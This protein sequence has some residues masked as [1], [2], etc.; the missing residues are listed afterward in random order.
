MQARG[1]T[2]LPRC[3]QLRNVWLF[4]VFEMS[5]CMLQTQKGLPVSAARYI[6]NPS[7]DSALPAQALYM[8][9]TA[10]VHCSLTS[11]T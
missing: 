10:L 9:C 7:K 2:Q 4:F 6:Q 3:L 1:W 11:D 5:A 8:N